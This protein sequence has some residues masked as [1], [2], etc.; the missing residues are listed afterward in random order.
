MSEKETWS[1]TDGEKHEQ[2]K[3]KTVWI[4]SFVVA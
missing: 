2:N 4:L 1:E 3:L